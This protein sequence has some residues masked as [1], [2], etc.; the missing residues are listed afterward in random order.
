MISSRSASPIACAVDCRLILKPR[1]PSPHFLAPRRTSWLFCIPAYVIRLRQQNLQL[2]AV[3]AGVPWSASSIVLRSVRGCW[4]GTDRIFRHCLPH[5]GQESS[6][7]EIRCSTSSEGRAGAEPVERS[8][9]EPPQLS[10]R[11]YSPFP[12]TRI[13]NRLQRPETQRSEYRIPGKFTAVQKPSTISLLPS[14][15]EGERADRGLAARLMA[16]DTNLDPSPAPRRSLGT[17]F[18]IA[19]DD[20]PWPITSLCKRRPTS[21]PS[22]VVIAELSSLCSSRKPAISVIDAN[23]RKVLG[24]GLITCSMS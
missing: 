2:L 12:T 5:P 10:R 20:R 3:S 23:G 22:D 13:R 9:V 18:D 15:S 7:R 19:H 21:R 8:G 16:A 1:T 24:P 4:P 14:P 6:V 17:G 11:F